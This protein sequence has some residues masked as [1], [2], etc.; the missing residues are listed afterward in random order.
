M[1]L[2]FRNMKTIH[3]DTFIRIIRINI[4][5]SVDSNQISSIELATF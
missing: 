4:S 1:D 2:R 3:P 5:L